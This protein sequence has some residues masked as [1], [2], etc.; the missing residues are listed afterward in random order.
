MPLFSVIIPVYNRHEMARW[1]IDS[2]LA[3]TFRDYELFVVDDGSTDGTVRLE[4][5]YRGRVTWLRRARGG[6]SAA[7]N[8]GIRVSTAPWITFLDS[9]DRWLPGKLERQARYIR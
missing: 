4:E 6:V 1:A 2:V 8:D 5:E 9:D 7:R 3:Q